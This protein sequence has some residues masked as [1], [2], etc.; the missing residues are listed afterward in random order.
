MLVD[1]HAHLYSGK[2]D[3]DRVAMIARAK[4]IGIE[5]VYLPNIDQESIEPM[6]QLEKDY[7]GFCVPMMG[8]HPCSVDADY[9][10]QLEV[11]KQWL[12]QRSFCAVGEIGVDLYWDKTYRKE[13]EIAFVKQAE[14]AAE[15][16]IPIVIHSRESTDILIN[17]IKESGINNLS[18]IFHCFG[19]STA[20]AEAI[21]E[22]GFYMGIGGVLTFKNS[23]LDKVL[24]SVPLD[25]L[26]LETDA[27]YLAPHPNRGKRNESSYVRIVAERLA[28]VKGLDLEEVARVTTQNAYAIFKQEEKTA[29]GI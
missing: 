22:L 16:N 5:K 2:F 17:L 1:T 19:G 18:G 9:E 29:T 23:G 4:A 26:V 25:R 11:V 12:D 27:P 7:P 13:Q 15:L 20:Q 14:W 8:L 3:S 10:A 21:M 28:E 6:L 24:E